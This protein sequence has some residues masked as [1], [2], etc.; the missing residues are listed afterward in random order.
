MKYVETYTPADALDI[1]SIFKCDSC[2]AAIFDR[3]RHDIFHRALRLTS[4]F[5]SGYKR[6][7]EWLRAKLERQP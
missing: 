1:Q 4:G 6:S 5:N 7:R 3:S 2:G